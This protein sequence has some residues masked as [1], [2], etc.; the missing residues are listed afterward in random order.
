MRV[1][2]SA[3]IAGFAVIGS[4]GFSAAGPAGSADPLRAVLSPL[5]PAFVRALERGDVRHPSPQDITPLQGLLPFVDPTL[6]S[7]YDLRDEYRVT[8]IRGQFPVVT[9]TI[10]G[11]FASLESTLKPYETCDFSERHLDG[12]S[13]ESDALEANVGAM[14]RWSDPVLED[15]DPWEG[16]TPYDPARPAVK[17][18]QKVVFLPPRADA[19]DNDRIKRAVM[20]RGGVAVEMRFSRSLLNDT[21]D[22][23]YTT[24]E[25]P[26]VH[27]VAVIGWDDLFAKEKFT[28]QAPG[29][30]AFI[31]KNSLGG[32]FGA[33]GYFYVSY[34][35]A[36][37]GRFSLPAVVLAEPASGLIENYQYDPVGCTARLGFSS[38]TA[39]FANQFVAVSNDPLAA[40][41]FYSYG[42]A[43]EYEVFVYTGAA[44]GL[45]QSGTL[46]AQFAGTLTEAGYHTL[47]L[48]EPVPLA[49]N[50][51]FSVVVRLRSPGNN[52]PI[53]I[54]H[55][56]PGFDADFNAL[57][58]QSFISSDGQ[59]WSDLVTYEGPTY[60]RS[61]V[62]L[63]AFA[64]YAPVYPPA[65][66]RV[67]R[68]VNDLI[69]YKEYVDRL[70]WAVHPSNTEP[71][72]AYRIYRKEKSAPND[73]YVFLAE[74]GTTDLSYYVRG[75]TAT[76]A[77][78]YRV[79]AVTSS[80]RESDPSEVVD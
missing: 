35:D 14:A 3:A 77:Y 74:T 62:C 39:W 24:V 44:P 61:N 47:R 5:N 17:H 51:R 76:S 79:T 30:G 48:P 37:F 16:G 41:S 7:A 25:T 70:S 34:Y 45:P 58:G 55:P 63:K 54:E 6:P 2:I 29:D 67:E 66:L 56:V 12:G 10:F 15:D 73:S 13:E 36:F 21:Y 71:I 72:A 46:A 28:P 27:A 20:D 65:Y 68:L 9:C 64:G 22:S 75:L 11:L 32:N 38:E 26:D 8:G 42:E 40:V 18:V 57:P 80:G 49:V 43:G 33:A 69:F 59:I 53:P 52:Y 19:L 1:R 78:A 60:A 31:C 50:E 23:Y 4:L